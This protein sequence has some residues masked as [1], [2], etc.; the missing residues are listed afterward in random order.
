MTAWRSPI[1]ATERATLFGL[2]VVGGR[3]VA[4]GAID[5]ELARALGATRRYDGPMGKSDRAFMVGALALVTF[6]FPVVYRAWF[7]IFTLA[8]LLTVMTCW[9]RIAR[10]LA[11]LQ[12]KQQ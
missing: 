4:Y 1:F 9:N 5:P 10:A 6:F 8:A 7:W 3:K 12:A 11:E 2:P